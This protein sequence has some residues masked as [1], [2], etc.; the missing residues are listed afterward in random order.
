M[1]LSIKKNQLLAGILTVEVRKI[2]QVDST[3]D[4]QSCL[5]RLDIAGLLRQIYICTDKCTEPGPD[6]FL[7]Q[8]LYIYTN[9]CT[10]F[11]WICLF[12]DTIYQ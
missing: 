5:F 12:V 6:V 7:L 10:V 2:F 1:P 8:V 11:M 3:N 4:Q 9:I